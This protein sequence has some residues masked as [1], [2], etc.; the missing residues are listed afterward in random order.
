MNK[1]PFHEIRLTKK[2]IYY[3][4]HIRIKIEVL[5]LTKVTN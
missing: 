1:I 5:D 2:S 3:L 4:L